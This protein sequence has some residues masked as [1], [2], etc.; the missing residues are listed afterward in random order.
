MAIKRSGIEFVKTIVVILHLK[1]K[2]NEREQYGD[3]LQPQASGLILELVPPTTTVPSCS[4][5][6]FYTNNLFPPQ[7]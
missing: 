2:S 4:Q 7:L 1:T 6:G 3:Q 5:N